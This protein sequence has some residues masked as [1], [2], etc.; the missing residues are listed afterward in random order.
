[1]SSTP[2]AVVENTPEAHTFDN[3]TILEVDNLLEGWPEYVIDIPPNDHLGP[4]VR[5]QLSICM[6]V[7]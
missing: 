4:Q 5:Q 1:M 6:L 3:I 2:A 7:N